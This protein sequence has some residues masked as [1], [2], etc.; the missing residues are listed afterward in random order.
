MVV[1]HSLGA[2]L[3]QRLAELGRARAI[4]LI[5]PAPPGMLT[6]QS[7][8]LRHFVPQM[9]K[10]MT[11]RPFIMAPPLARPWHSTSCLRTSGPRSMRASLTSPAK[12]TG[13]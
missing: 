2:L 11:G 10:I 3:A 5:A 7:V 9:P 6:A 4:V 12:S 1:G 13:I 8:A